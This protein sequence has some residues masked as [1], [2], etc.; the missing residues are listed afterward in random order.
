MSN[1]K[2]KCQNETCTLRLEC[3]R[4]TSQTN[5]NQYYLIDVNPE[6]GSDCG[7]FCDFFIQNESDF[8]QVVLK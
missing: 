8:I 5:Y 6:Y 7:W 3:L 4:F 2:S 1:D